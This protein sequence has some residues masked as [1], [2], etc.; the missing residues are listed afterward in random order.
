LGVRIRGYI[1]TAYDCTKDADTPLD[2]LKMVADK[3]LS[4]GAEELCIADTAGFANP[5]DM[6]QIIETLKDRCDLKQIAFHLHDTSGMALTNALV[7]MQLGITKFDTSVA[8]L[9]GCPF[10]LGAGGNLATEE[11]VNL[12]HQLGITTGVD[13][14]KLMEASHFILEKLGLE[15]ANSK[16]YNACQVRSCG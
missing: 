6:E 12:A 11:L 13:L 3:L 14:N 2:K 15:R 1:S 7:S 16:L 4:F 9:G 10:A 8:G 5:H